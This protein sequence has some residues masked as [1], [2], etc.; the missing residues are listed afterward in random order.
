MRTSSHLCTLAAI[1]IAALTACSTTSNET[2]S[3]VQDS[4]T[5]ATPAMGSHGA[6]EDMKLPPGWSMEDMQA[7]MAAGTPGKMHEHLMQ[8]V[9]VWKGKNTMWMAPDT[10]PMTSEC[11]STVTSAMDGRYTKCEM[12]GEMPGMGMYHGLG[13][14]GF[15]NVSQ[16]FV[17][18]WIDN[19]GSGIM[20]GTGELSSDGKTLTWKYTYNCPIR[21]K[22][23]TMREVHRITGDNTMTLEMFGDDPKTGKE[24]KMMEIELTRT[25]T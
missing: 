3:S 2:H 4:K 13:F 24:F 8:G 1:A 16:K 18:T 25:R 12:E 6:G 23:A 14:N 11:T 7:C 21:K 19:H 9:G 20:Q 15:D 5:A 22:P 10:E 17:S